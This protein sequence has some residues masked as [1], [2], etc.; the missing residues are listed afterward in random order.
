[1]MLFL[2]PSLTKKVPATE[3]MMQTAPITSGYIII[4]LWV[5]STKKI[6]ASSMV[7]TMVTA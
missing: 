2:A 6:A 4:R 7:A 1:M 5:R 3:P